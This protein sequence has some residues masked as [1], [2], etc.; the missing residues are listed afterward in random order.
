[1]TDAFEIR[2]ARPPDLPAIG[3]LVNAATQSRYQPDKATLV[4]WLLG[5]GLWLALQDGA[6]VGVAAWQA[7]NLVSVTDVLYV[8]GTRSMADAAAK[9]LA[10]IEAEASTLM[11]EVSIVVLPHWTPGNVAGLLRL[12]GYKQGTTGELHRIW[13]EVLTGFSIDQRTLMVKP[14]RGRLVTT[15]L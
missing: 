6:L 2:R 4:E 13:Q 1:M 8:T 3:E 5:R 10:K 7:E 15:P 11:C 9:L 14:L 12:Q